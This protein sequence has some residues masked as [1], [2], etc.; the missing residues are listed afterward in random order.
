MELL[1]I[2]SLFKGFQ[3]PGEDLKCYIVSKTGEEINFNQA[4]CNDDAIVENMDIEN[5][6][7]DTLTL[8]LSM[9]IQGDNN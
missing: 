3:L 4:L 7:S 2:T 8:A 1:W 5:T 6:E 9:Q